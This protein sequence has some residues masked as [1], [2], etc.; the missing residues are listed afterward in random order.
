MKIKRLICAIFVL[1]AM[2]LSF[3][4]SAAPVAVPVANDADPDT[5][6]VSPRAEQT[7][8]YYRIYNGHLQKRLWSYTRGIWL[9]DWIDC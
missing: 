9:T 7:E 6:T 1:A 3:A 4:A 2:M 8:W 5:S